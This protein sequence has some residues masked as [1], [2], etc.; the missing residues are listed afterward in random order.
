MLIFRTYK[1]LIACNSPFAH[2]AIEAEDK[3]G[4]MLPCNLIIQELKDRVEVAAI[5]PIA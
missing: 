1:I 2:K 3:I 4:I 5:T